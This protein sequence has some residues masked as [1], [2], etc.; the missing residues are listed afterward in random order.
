MENLSSAKVESNHESPTKQLRQVITKLFRP[1]AAPKPKKRKKNVL[2]NKSPEKSSSPYDLQVSARRRNKEPRDKLGDSDAEKESKKL[3]NKE[4]MEEYIKEALEKRDE[5]KVYYYNQQEREMAKY[6]F[7][8]KLADLKNFGAG[9]Y[10]F[11]LYAKQIS[12]VFM[13]LAVFSIVKCYLL[14]TMDGLKDSSTLVPFYMTYS[15]ANASGASA[16]TVPNQHLFIF[17]DAAPTIILTIYLVW[18]TIKIPR[19]EK[20]LKEEYYTTSDYAIQVL[21]LDPHVKHQEVDEAFEQFG[22]VVQVYLFKKFRETVNMMNEMKRVRK[23]LDKQGKSV[24]DLGGGGGSS[25]GKSKQELRSE[26]RIV[27]MRQKF[28]ELTLKVRAQRRSNDVFC[29]FVIF[30]YPKSKQDALKVK[31]SHKL[32]PKSR[33][34][35]FLVKF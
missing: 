35:P 33:H 28:L 18:F 8:D 16:A 13:I 29:A 12:I 26:K 22:P 27:D 10:L 1:S 5:R 19:V 23:I 32:P 25:V 24:V 3:K 20:Q 9:V 2:R 14:S 7:C 17:V 11:F 15:L 4:K 21:N 31:E 34:R 30:E 6:K